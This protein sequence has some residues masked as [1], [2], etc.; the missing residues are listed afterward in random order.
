MRPGVTEGAEYGAVAVELFGVVRA[1][2]TVL[3]DPPPPLP[4][5]LPPPFLNTLAHLL[6]LPTPYGYGKHQRGRPTW[7]CPVRKL[8][9]NVEPALNMRTFTH[10][11]LCT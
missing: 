6:V 4:P 3:S 9:M 8:E 2:S 11:S 5:P 7:Q 10:L 1:V